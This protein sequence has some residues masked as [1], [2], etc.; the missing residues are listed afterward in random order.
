M[1]VA[2]YVHPIVHTLGPQFNYAH[3]EFSTKLLQTLCRDAGAECLLV[4]GS[5]FFL[6]AIEEGR[7][8]SLH[9]L[10]VAELDE[11][12]LYRKVSAAGVLPTSLDSLAYATG[13]E[14]HNAL[15]ILAEEVFRSSQGFEPDV[16][17]AFAIQIDFLETVWP[18]ALR[19][20]SEMG[21]YSRNPYPYSLFFDRLGLYGRSVIG[22]AGQ[23]LRTRAA[24]ADA[25]AL[26][27][28][29]RS[30]SKTAL[31]A[32]NPFMIHDLQSC[33]N[34]L[35]LLPLQVS[36]HYSFDQQAIYRNQFEFLL[37]VLSKAPQDV[38]VLATEY[39][40]FGPVLK[41]W[42]PQQN[43]DFF[44]RNFPN[45]IFESDFRAYHTPS[46]FLV[47]NVDG[48]WS[49]SSNVGYQALLFGKFL[50]S[51][52]TSYL[53]SVADAT[54]LTKFFDELDQG[55]RGNKDD[56]VAWQIERYLVP[57][58]LLAD[59]R[60]MCDY[61]ERRIIAAREASDPLDA[62]VPIADIDHLEQAWIVSA[63]VPVATLACESVS[64]QLEE[65]LQSTSWRITAPLRALV[66]RLRLWRDGVLKL[67]ARPISNE[68]RAL[69]AKGFSL[70]RA[71]ITQSGAFTI[72]RA[73]GQEPENPETGDAR[74]AQARRISR[75]AL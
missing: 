32:V 72:D 1:K 34:R 25:R 2:C 45:F 46:Q 40:E 39:V 38:G 74:E 61:F 15:R 5:R 7:A 66:T 31:D 59:G 56:F 21:P 42:G 20:H 29:F 8:R 49:V 50:G 75:P 36:H 6:R 10:R 28:A 67:M 30:N 65:I 53:A 16:V 54:T 33:F 24:S 12:S 35:C 14:D 41:Q 60:W 23:R 26:A 13:S 55:S 68:V 57:D 22:Q 58:V 73:V 43:L 17:I 27:S 51:P 3:F 9:G 70:V 11:F 44:R 63:P 19:L 47:P 64:R 48:V 18:N 4:A 71:M 52:A 69:I 62:F 37:D